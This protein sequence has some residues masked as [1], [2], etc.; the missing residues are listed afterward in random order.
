M[1]GSRGRERYSASYWLG[2][3]VTL[4]SD[5]LGYGRAPLP[6]CGTLP[7]SDNLMIIAPRSLPSLFGLCSARFSIMS[8]HENLKNNVDNIGELP[9]SFSTSSPWGLAESE[10]MMLENQAPDT[11]RFASAQARAQ[12]L[13]DESVPASAPASAPAPAPAPASASVS[14]DFVGPI[15]W[16]LT[17]AQEQLPGVNVGLKEARAWWARHGHD[18]RAD[19]RAMEWARA[20][21]HDAYASWRMAVLS[22]M[23]KRTGFPTG[24]WRAKVKRGEKGK[25]KSLATA[26]APEAWSVEA[27]GFEAFALAMAEAWE[28]NALKGFKIPRKR[29][30]ALAREAL[31]HAPSWGMIEALKLQAS[32]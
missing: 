4:M 3:G 30:E 21:G 29:F 28:R 16:M 7:W 1:G 31:D 26:Q 20:A 6:T 25:A 5:N 13:R 19:K 15:P 23:G 10:S 17:L 32:I 8:R 11:R 14:H 9:I 2:S 22:A 12:A 18:V 24:Q 27:Q